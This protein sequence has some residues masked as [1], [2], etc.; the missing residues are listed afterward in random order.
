VRLALDELKAQ[1]PD[2]ELT[3]A[4]DFVTPVAEEYDGSMVLLYEG[5]ILAVVVVWLFLRNL[6]ATFVSAVALPLSVIPA[7]IG[8]GYLGFAST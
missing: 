7:F 5:A 2:M 6:R 1:H 3:E 4:F 8:M